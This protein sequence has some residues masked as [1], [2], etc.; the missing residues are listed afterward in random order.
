M[1]ATCKADKT[2][3]SEYCDTKEGGSVGG[4]PNGRIQRQGETAEEH[5]FGEEQKEEEIDRKH[6]KL[7]KEGDVMTNLFAAIFL[8]GKLD[9]AHAACADCLAKNPFPRLGGNSSA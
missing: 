9:F 8:A 7:W 2:R 1:Q 3:R 6:G 4:C 5:L